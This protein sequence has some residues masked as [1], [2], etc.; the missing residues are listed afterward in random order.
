M[1][2]KQIFIIFLF[3]VFISTMSFA[4]AADDVADTPVQVADTQDDIQTA[5]SG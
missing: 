4:C 3:M 5:D 1:K 2:K